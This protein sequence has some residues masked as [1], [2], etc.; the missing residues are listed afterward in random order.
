MVPTNDTKLLLCLLDQSVV[1]LQVSISF[2]DAL[3]IDIIC[4]LTELTHILVTEIRVCDRVFFSLDSTC[5]SLTKKQ[6]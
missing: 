1:V 2:V 3:S 6:S 5:Y 4:D